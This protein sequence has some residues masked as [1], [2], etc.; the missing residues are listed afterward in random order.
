M[1]E[2]PGGHAVGDNIDQQNRLVNWPFNWLFRKRGTS[3][4]K[5]VTFGDAAEVSGALVWT[6]VSLILILALWFIST[7]VWGLPQE[8]YDYADEVRAG[9]SEDESYGQR[10]LLRD[11]DNSADDP[12]AFA[13][14]PECSYTQW[15]SELQFD[16]AWVP[17]V[18]TAKAPGS[19]VAGRANVFVFP[20]LTAGNIAYKIT[21]RL[22]GARAFGPLLQ[23]TG[24]VIHDLSRGC[25]VDDIVTVATIAACQA[26]GSSARWLISPL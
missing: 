16:A 2:G 26:A 5:T 24:G 13:G 23:G 19:P 15:L 12:A 18:A 11:C 25:S 6:I 22:A 9:L 21:Q 4:R 20:D 3:A 8:W 10:D 17:E 7:T 1:V 14:L